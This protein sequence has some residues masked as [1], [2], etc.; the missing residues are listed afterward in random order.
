MGFVDDEHVA[1]NTDKTVYKKDKGQTVKANIKNPFAAQDYAIIINA[2]EKE[3]ANWSDEDYALAYE[4]KDV[5]STRNFSERVR[6]QM[7]FYPGM[8]Q[9]SSVPS[10]DPAYTEAKKMSEK[11]LGYWNNAMDSPDGFM[12]ALRNNSQDFDYTTIFGTDASA[13]SRAE[14]IGK[15]VTECIPC[16]GRKLDLE[17][18]L[19]DGD[20][21]EVHAI[22]TKIRTDLLDRIKGLLDDPGMNIDI[23]ELLSLLSKQCPQDLVA[24]MI[25]FSQYLAKLNLDIKFNIDFI[26]NLVGAILSPFL[27]ALSQ[28]LDKWIQMIVG[29]MLCVL[30]HINEVIITVQ[31]A[32]IPLSEGSLSVD[33]DIGVADPQ[34]E[35]Q[36]LGL[37]A[38]VSGARG[39]WASGEYERFNTPDSQKYNAKEPD[40]PEE[41]VELAKTEMK[42]GFN[43]SMSK[44]EREATDAKWKELRIKHQKEQ[45]EIP[46]PL[47]AGSQR[48]GTRWSKDDIPNSE[49]ISYS[50]GKDDYHPPEKQQKVARSEKYWDPAPMAN[51]IVQMRNIMQGALQ[52]VNDWFT[53]ITQMIYDLLG[54][55]YG[56][57]K[58]KTGTSMLKSRVIQLINIIRSML[59]AISQNGLKCG[60][61]SN[62][63]QEQ[64]K[65]ILEDGLNKFS[66]TKFKVMDNGDIKV[67]LPS[68]VDAPDAQSVSDDVEDF[69]TEKAKAEANA[70]T[71]EEAGVVVGPDINVDNDKANIDAVKQKSVESGIIVKNCLKD[72]TSDQL[73]KARQ[74]IAEYE[75]RANG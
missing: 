19:P 55:D 52:Y 74:W 45:R 43:P 3:A 57:M 39:S 40:W 29:P 65:F 63:D 8:H 50:F 18:I 11:R 20:L 14:H 13:K 34:H 60:E 58:K 41:E 4:Y 31:Q 71:N 61:N 75:R 53:Y 46:P 44:A 54:T 33:A 7:N 27:N 23:C 37:D 32:K 21:L 51:A 17:E 9:T 26:T 49:K 1:L 36:Y 24:M 68:S 64:L 69:Q 2:F 72:M 28:W 5:Y 62:F 35:N 38:G 70:K 48:D 73:D 16:F 10:K 42:E 66:P 6:E 22:N 15:I 59:S 47:R 30:D 12:N 67:I 56:W 25:L